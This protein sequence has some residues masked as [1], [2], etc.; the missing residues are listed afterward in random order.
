MTRLPKQYAKILFEL[1][2]D[3][4]KEKEEEAMRAF[5]E[6]LHRE[7]ALLKA[8]YI[9]REFETYAKEQEGVVAL[10]ITTA[11]TL[12]K[13]EIEHI[14]R[15]FGEKTETTVSVEERVIGGVKVATGEMVLDATVRTKL[16]LLKERLTA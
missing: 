6:L 3:I 2:S 14:A 15:T 12:D 8:P 7:Q 5:V 16:D 13:K 4:P 10:H 1:L 11:R 9:I